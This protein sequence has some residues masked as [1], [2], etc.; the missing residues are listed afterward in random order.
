MYI[1]E[2][3]SLTPLAKK[4]MAAPIEI[5]PLTSIIFN[6]SLSIFGNFSTG[7]LYQIN[8]DIDYQI[9]LYKKFEKE[10]EKK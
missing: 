5:A 4:R 8:I 6:K 1:V 9:S 3:S 10:T 7:K 2:L